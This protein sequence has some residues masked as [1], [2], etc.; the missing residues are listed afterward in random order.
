MDKRERIKNIQVHNNTTLQALAVGI[1][2]TIREYPLSTFSVL[3]Y[4]GNDGTGWG[5]GVQGTVVYRQ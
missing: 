4:M 3:D 2:L 5:R 1:Q